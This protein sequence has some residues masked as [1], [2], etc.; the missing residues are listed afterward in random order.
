MLDLLLFAICRPEVCL[1]N[2]PKQLE[3]DLEANFGNGRVI[4]PLAQLIADEGVLRPGKLVEAKDDP[5]VTKFLS[6]EI[7]AGVGDVRVLDAEDHCH[8]APELGEQIDRVVAPRCRVV[9]GVGSF[10]RAECTA[11]HISCEVGDA[12]GDPRVQLDGEPDVSMITC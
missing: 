10:M 1:E 7:A 9:S 3:K 12:G 4:T 2:P 6:D 11:V 8:F 5:R